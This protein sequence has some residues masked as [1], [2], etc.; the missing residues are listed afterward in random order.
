MLL[1][2]TITFVAGML[3][4]EKII[5]QIIYNVTNRDIQLVFPFFVCSSKGAH[6]FCVHRKYS[7]MKTR[8]NF[9]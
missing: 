9:E 3:S 2:Y 6:L 4:T 5:P 1:N 8:I 7:K